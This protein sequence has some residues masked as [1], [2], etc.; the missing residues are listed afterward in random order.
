MSRALYKCEL[1]AMEQGERVVW[2]I[3]KRNEG[4]G[5]LWLNQ[6]NRILS[7]D[8]PVGQMSLG[9]QQRKQNSF[10]SLE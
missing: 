3:T 7:E 2:K 1:T 9:G 4:F 5:G 8:C 10:G 6:P